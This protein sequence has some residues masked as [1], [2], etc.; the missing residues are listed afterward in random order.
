[1][2]GGP[3]MMVPGWKLEEVMPTITQKAVD[4]IHARTDDPGEKPFFLF[5]TLTAPHTPI[6]PMDEYLGKSDA[7]LYGDFVNEV[8]DCVGKVLKALDD[9]GVADNT[10]VLFTSD[11]GSPGRNGE[12]WSGPVSSVKRDYGHDPSFPWKGVKSDIWEGGHH[13]PYIV[14][15]PGNIKAGSLSEELIGHLDFMQT[16]AVILGSDLPA[17]AAPDSYNILP[18][19]LQENDK[20]LR[21]ALV[22]HSGGGMFAIRQGPWKLCFGLGPAGF[23]GGFIKPSDGE[24]LGQLYNLDLDPGEKNN[25]Y[26]ENPDVVE[27]LTELMEKYKR[28]GS[29]IPHDK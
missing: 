3:G 26:F 6:A 1:L 27:H 12:Y 2:F 23:S 4:Y 13:V 18:A 9:A 8:D 11:N 20:P 10:L 14:R 28:E 7:G 29:S 17:D 15:W 25:V 19:Y 24:P 21:K 5:F 22:H 16:I